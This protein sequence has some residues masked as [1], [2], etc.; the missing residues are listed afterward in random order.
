ME[1]ANRASGASKDAAP[2]RIDTERLHQLSS[3]VLNSKIFGT[4]KVGTTPL[5]NSYFLILD[6]NGLLLVKRPSLN[7]CDSVYSFKEDVGEF[8][9]EEF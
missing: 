7:G 3:V 6:M 9:Y 2:I 1:E 5:V 8:L 4:P